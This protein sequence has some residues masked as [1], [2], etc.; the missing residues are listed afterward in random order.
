MNG[1]LVAIWIKRTRR[2]AMERVDTAELVAG[3]G[4]VGN[5][6]QGG[7]RQVTLI[8]EEAWQR[9]Q[10]ELGVSFDPS[11]RRA[12]LMLR[13]IPLRNSAGNILTIGT[14][15][16][17]IAGETRPCQRM[18]EAVPGLRQAMSSHWGGGAFAEVLV[19][20]VINVGDEAVWENDAEQL[21]FVERLVDAARRLR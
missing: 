19:D 11:V 7:R 14:T 4:V 10:R 13:G 17:R 3:R 5:A 6:N 20:G 18:D 8:E 15:R 16:L 2:G 21:S 9:L 12:N 1:S